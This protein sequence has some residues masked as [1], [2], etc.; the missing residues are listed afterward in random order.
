MPNQLCWKAGLYFME[1]HN[2]RHFRYV[3]NQMF[4]CW[5]PGLYQA[6]WHDE[7]PTL[8]WAINLDSHNNLDESWRCRFQPTPI[9]IPDM[10]VLV[11]IPKFSWWAWVEIMFWGHGCLQ[12]RS[13]PSR[14]TVSKNKKPRLQGLNCKFTK[15]AVYPVRCCLQDM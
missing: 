9:R 14:L 1:R 10:N 7:F 6:A 11:L 4:K 5:L 13:P 3:S 15:G 2:I 12:L 8:R